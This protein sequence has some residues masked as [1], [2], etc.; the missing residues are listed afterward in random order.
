MSDVVRNTETMPY[1]RKRR[2][3]QH[4]DNCLKAKEMINVVLKVQ[5]RCFPMAE[6][7]VTLNVALRVQGRCFPR[8]EEAVMVVEK[9]NVC[10]KV[11]L[12]R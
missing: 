3:Q 9:F 1:H 7:T 12:P 5:G 6:K 8:V 11:A 10:V 2:Q 4:T